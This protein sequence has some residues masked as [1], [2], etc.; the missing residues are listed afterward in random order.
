MECHS[1]NHGNE[2][3]I[4]DSGCMDEMPLKSCYKSSVPEAGCDESGRGCLAGP[5]YA[6]AVILPADYF[7]PLL[8]DSK[9][10][11]PP[12]R[13]LLRKDIEK[14]ALAFAVA[15]ADH[16][17]IDRMNILRASLLAMHRALKKLNP[18]PGHIIVDGNRFYKFEDVPYRAIIGG[19]GL[20]FSISAAS[21]LAKTYRDDFMY[22]LHEEYPQY[23]WDQ[24][25]G[26]ATPEHRKALLENGAS[27]FH[28]RTFQ[29]F[30]TQYSIDF[31][32]FD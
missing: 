24:N 25:K 10:L 15:S 17:E 20:F 23:H 13:E 28:R 14:D 29:L 30:S 18:R 3:Y 32:K 16:H 8:N 22:S 6:A 19:D 5:V 31:P 26:Y 4:E 12:V 21:V 2:K 7:H 9:K 11:D 27:P 1:E